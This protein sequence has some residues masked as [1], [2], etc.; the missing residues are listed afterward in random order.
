MGAVD[1][2]LSTHI[3]QG[4]IDGHSGIDTRGSK[5]LN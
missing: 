3:M 4:V 5:Y 1:I 2:L